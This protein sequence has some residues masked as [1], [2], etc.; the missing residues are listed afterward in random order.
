MCTECG[1][2]SKCLYSTFPRTNIIKIEHCS[3]CKKVVDKYIEFDP[4]LIFLD[5]LLLRTAAFRHVL[6]NREI[7]NIH[8]KLAVLCLF[9]DGYMKWITRN[10]DPETPVAQYETKHNITEDIVFQA[11]SQLQLYVMTSIA[12]LE[13]A[14]L[15]CIVSSIYFILHEFFIRFCTSDGTN[16]RWAIYSL[17]RSFPSSFNIREVLK[18]LLLANCGKLLQ[19]PAIV[20]AQSSSQK[21]VSYIYAHVLC[22]NIMCISIVT[23]FSY[24]LTIPVTLFGFSV[25]YYLQPTWEHVYEYQLFQFN[26]E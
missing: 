7:G 3:K 26:S 22:T 25:V 13:L 17:S 23:N 2:P 6:C 18:A 8:W 24:F 9:S 19:L 12:A 20:W 5:L 21:Y 1:A 14:L 16:S 15:V 4:T 11:A 10:T